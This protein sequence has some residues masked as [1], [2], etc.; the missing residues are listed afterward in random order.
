V[1]HRRDG[2]PHEL[3][4]DFNRYSQM[5]VTT[6]TKTARMIVFWNFS[7]LLLYQ[8]HATTE[9]PPPFLNVQ[10]QLNASHDIITHYTFSPT[11]TEFARVADDPVLIF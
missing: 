7:L 5:S 11:P 8:I 3:P 2:S 1:A 10:G 9:S 4:L 6:A